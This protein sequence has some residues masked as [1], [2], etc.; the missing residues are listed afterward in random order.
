[1]FPQTGRRKQNKPPESEIPTATMT[2][3]GET[4]KQIEKNRNPKESPS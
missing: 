4:S 2:T 1:M 3:K